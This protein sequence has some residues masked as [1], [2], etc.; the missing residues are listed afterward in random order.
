[1]VTA[2]PS[3]TACCWPT[4][5][6]STAS[7]PTP[8]H[9]STP[10]PGPP[11]A[12]ARRPNGRFG[13]AAAADNPLNEAGDF[14]VTSD[15]LPAAQFPQFASRGGRRLRGRR[16]AA[17]RPGR[18]RLVRRRPARRRRL[19]A[20]DPD[21]R[22]DRVRPPQAPTLRAQLSYDTEEGYDNVIVEAHT[23]GQRRLD[24]AARAGRAHQRPTVPAECEAGLPARGA[25]LPAR[26]T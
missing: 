3:R 22:P 24:D 26:T 25:P 5:S 21:G 23:V 10:P 15:I 12:A 20:A 4:T 11:A 1:M 13:G 14:T 2:D 7:A 19:H 9:R 8:G 17:V 16:A 6:A 18:G